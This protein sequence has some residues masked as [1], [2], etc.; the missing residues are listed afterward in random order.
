MKTFCAISPRTSIDHINMQTPA[1]VL[2]ISMETKF[3]NT[4]QVPIPEMS[5]SEALLSC[6][7]RYCLN[8]AHIEFERKYDIVAC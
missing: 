8:I 6:P 7:N 3:R 5:T 4:D 2:E 1:L